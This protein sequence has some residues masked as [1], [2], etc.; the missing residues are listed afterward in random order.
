M[1]SARDPSPICCFGQAPKPWSAED[2]LLA[3]LAMFF[4]LQDADNQRELKLERMRATLPPQ[5]FAFL[6][7]SGTEW[8]APL[9]GAA[10]GDPALPPADEI[11]LRQID[12]AGRRA[13]ARAAA[14]GSA[15]TTSRSPAR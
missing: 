8:D 12:V 4:D 14:R 3:P 1:R 13:T 15:A 9:L 11:D 5:V 6:T 7:A 10:I 2:S